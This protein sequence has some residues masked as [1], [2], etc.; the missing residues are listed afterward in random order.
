MDMIDKIGD[1][2]AVG[3]KKAADKAKELV[4]IANLKSQIASC[5]EVIKKNYME[6][7]RLY[8]E[9]HRDDEDA[10]FAKQ[11]KAIINA[12]AGVADLQSKI[13]ALKGL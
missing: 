13:R 6:I 7:G 2:L 9:Q 1:T 3:G 4:E 8:M 10:E 12:Q 5:E 11:R